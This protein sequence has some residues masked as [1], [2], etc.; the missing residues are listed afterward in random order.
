MPLPVTLFVS[1]VAGD[2]IIECCER[3]L[4]LFQIKKVPVA[5]VDLAAR[6]AERARME[7]YCA[8]D[9]TLPQALVGAASH[10]RAIG[11]VELQELEDA[12]ARPAPPR[13]RAAVRHEM[14]SGSCI[15]CRFRKFV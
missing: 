14:G 5:L 3:A 1:S 2:R 4:N 9:A 6:P 15:V 13:R 11:M 8:P 10:G 7:S 12:G